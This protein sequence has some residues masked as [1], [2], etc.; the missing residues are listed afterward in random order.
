MI[1]RALARLE[2]EDRENHLRR[3][4]TQRGWLDGQPDAVLDEDIAF[5]EQRVAESKVAVWRL[6]RNPEPTT[7][8]DW[9]LACLEQEALRIYGR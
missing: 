7:R 5:W 6:E 2:L 3:L 1:S 8:D 9:Y 4:Y